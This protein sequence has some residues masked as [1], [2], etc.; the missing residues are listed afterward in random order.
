MRI[1][2]IRSLCSFKEKGLSIDVHMPFMRNS[3]CNVFLEEC[4]MCFKM[5]GNGKK[6]IYFVRYGVCNMYRNYM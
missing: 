3:F 6:Y 5:F 4:L 1:T 2:L